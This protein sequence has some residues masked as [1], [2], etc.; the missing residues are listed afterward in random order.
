MLFLLHLSM[1]ISD[2]TAG[3]KR[4]LR[5][6]SADQ[7]RLARIQY[8]SGDYT[9]G[10][11]AAIHKTSLSSVQKRSANEK[12]TK[13]SEIVSAARSQLQQATTAAIADA[14]RK[15]ADKV[16]ASI[17]D[18]LQ[19]LIERE[20]R[21]HIKRAIV[22]ARRAFR[23][24]DKVSKGYKAVDS[25]TGQIEDI[26][27]DP[28]DEMHLASAEDKWDGIVRRNLGMSDGSVLAGPI[29]LAILANQAAVQVRQS[30]D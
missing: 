16:T 15:A 22:R 12:W 29:N 25:K 19:P 18:D 24:L 9:L 27:P 26:V 6:L 7:W 28:K 17:M 3:P 10:Q 8:E 1:S 4:M 2:E 13:S 20:K 11:I 21:A 5:P 23:R 30:N 14:A